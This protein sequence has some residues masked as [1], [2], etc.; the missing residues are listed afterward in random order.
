MKTCSS[1]G[2]PD[3]PGSIIAPKQARCHSCRRAGTHAGA[4][5]TQ[6]RDAAEIL[7]ARADAATRARQ[8]A[9][10]ESMAGHV[11]TLEAE[12]EALRAI[13]DSK[14]LPPIVAAPRK[15]SKSE[16]VPLILLSDWHVEEHVD[17]SKMHGTN[18]YTL[19]IAKRRSE[20]FFESALK[21]TKA[22]GST[23][24]VARVAV[25]LQG[26]FISGS[27]HD[28]LMETN[29]LGPG[30]AAAYARQLLARGI[31]HWLASTGL[32]F[33]F[34]CVGG[35]HGRMTHKTRIS[36]IAEN[37]LEVFMY[38]FL[39]SDLQSERAR[40]HIAP[41]DE[42]YADIFQ[43]YRVRFIHGD[44][45]GYQGGVGGISIPLNKWTLRANQTINANLTVLGHFHQARADRD[46]LCN[47]SLIGPSPYSKRFGFAPE[48][49]KQQFALIHATRGRT[50]VSDVWCD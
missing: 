27:I 5:P 39:A 44:Q 36:T 7:R 31:K 50:T 14:P 46:W 23:S 16:V 15:A 24:R 33:D 43:D 3:G 22:A 13:R 25:G 9:E 1:C 18:E 35:N 10:F 34:Y 2:R 17:K 4:A 38:E 47:G 37:S 26:D 19:A 49:P 6:P 41:G 11:R 30:P 45:I 28:E 48:R 21:L 29:Q 42:C 8:A 20:I 32:E 12:R 40:F